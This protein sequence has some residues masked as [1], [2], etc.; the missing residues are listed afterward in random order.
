MSGVSPVINSSEV[1]PCG[2]PAW[3]AVNSIILAIYAYQYLHSCLG[4]YVL[5]ISQ[6]HFLCISRITPSDGF[7]FESSLSDVCLWMSYFIKLAWILC[8]VRPVLVR[9]HISLSLA[10]H[11]PSQICPVLHGSPTSFP[12][13]TLRHRILCCQIPGINSRHGWSW[14]WHEGC[15]SQ[16]YTIVFWH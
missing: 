16:L 6:Y 14:L 3:L 9:H 7:W 5:N 4:Q 15:P 1:L 13:D 8:L 2:I 12:W 10:R 11:N